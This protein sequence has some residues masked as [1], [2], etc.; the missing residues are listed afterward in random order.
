MDNEVSS[1]WMHVS[2]AL[3][4]ILVA[5]TGLFAYLFINLQESYFD[6]QSRQY[7]VKLSYLQ[8][9]IKNMQLDLENIKTRT[10][11]NVSAELTPTQ[12]YNSVKN[13]VV[14]ISV[15]TTFGGATGS[16]FV[17]DEDGH[18]ITLR[19]Y[20]LSLLSNYP[21]PAIKLNKVWY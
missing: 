12:I 14:L 19:C 1:R 17:Y 13:S 6:L 20:L 5:Q 11:V 2:I 3:V 8:D 21:S 10:T 16:G 4:I 15:R 7:D 18:I 9:A